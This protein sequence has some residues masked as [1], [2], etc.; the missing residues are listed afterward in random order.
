MSLDNPSDKQMRT[1]VKISE[2]KTSSQE[3]FQWHKREQAFKRLQPPWVNATFK[4]IA[5]SGIQNEAVVTIETK[6]LF[7]TSRLTVKH[8]HYIENKQFCDTQIKGPLAYWDHHHLFIEESPSSFQM[9]DEINYCLPFGKIG[10]ALFGQ[11][12]NKELERLFRY[13]HQ[14]LKH[15]LPL[16][17]GVKPMKILMTGSSGLVGSALVPF[18]TTGGHQVMRLVRKKEKLAPDEIRWDPEQKLLDVASLEGF[19]AVIH[20]AGE[21]IAEGRWT[22][23]KKKQIRESRILTTEFLSRTLANLKNPPKVLISASATGIYGNR[24]GLVLDENSPPGTGFLAQVC[25][26]W[27]ASTQSASE[28]GIRVIHLRNGIVL[29]PQGGMLK[30]ILPPF[31]MGLGGK[32]G[33]GKQYMSWIAIDDLLSVILFC[34]EETKLVGAVNAVSPYPV[35]NEEFTAV[36]GKVL[37]RPTFMTI[38]PALA[39][40]AFGE[41]ADELLL[42]SQRV[43]PRQLLDAGFEFSFSDLEWTLRHLLGKYT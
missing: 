14:I 17:R 18:L 3:A 21:N 35:T 32:I 25:R 5:G 43:K 2:I 16:H 40:L 13:R 23:K 4:H 33:S 30:K 20:L 7:F 34:L 10:E 22:E 37:Y 27:E 24:E 8:H 11:Y 39:R 9:K 15:D 19:D 42:S 6:V 26:D 31:K 1:F 12:V 29:S 41:M 36:L 38:P 28:K